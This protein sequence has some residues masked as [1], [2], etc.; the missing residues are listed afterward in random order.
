MNVTKK[1]REFIVL[2]GES[3]LAALNKLSASSSKTLFVVENSGVLLGSVTDGDFRRWITSSNTLDLEQPVDR[4]MN[5]SCVS[6]P[7]TSQ[8]SDIFRYFRP[9]CKFIPLTDPVGRVVAVAHMNNNELTLGHWT[10]SENTPVFIIAEIG[11]NHNADI[12]MARSLIDKSISAGA[13]CVKFQM[14]DMK[15]LY[16]LR[17]DDVPMQLDLSAQYTID[18]LNKFQLDDDSLFTLFDYCHEK[19]VIPLCTPW[20]SSSLKKLDSYGMVGFK[21]ASADLTNHELLRQAALTNKPLIVSTGMST[22]AE[23][24]GSVSLLRHEAASFAL[25]HCNSTYPTP[26]K[27]VR[28]S[29]LKRL[30]ELS[31]SIVGY[32]GHERGIEVPIAAVALG[33]RIIEKHITL[34]KNLPG[35]DH[36]V[37]L[38]PEEFAEMVASI[39]IVEESLGDN[40]ERLVTQGELINREALAKSLFATRTLSPGDVITRDDISIKS[41][42]QGLP[43][44]RLPE[45]LGKKAVRTISSGSFYTERDITKISERKSFYCFNRPFGIPVRYHDFRELSNVCNLDFVEFHPSYHDL[46]IDPSTIIDANQKIGFSIH[47]PELFE[48]EHILDLASPDRSYRD[49]SICYLQHVVDIGNSLCNIFSDNFQP[50]IIINAGGWSRSGFIHKEDRAMLYDLV[51]GSLEKVDFGH[52]QPAIQTMPPFPWHFGGQSHHNIFIDPLEIQEFSVKTGYK[53]CLDTSHSMMACNFASQSLD[54]FLELVLPVTCYLHIV[55]AEG[56]DGEGVQIG[57]G[58]IPFNRLIDKL[59]THGPTLPFIPEIWQG[60]KNGGEGFRNAL[61]FL[62]RLGL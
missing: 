18:M 62:E 27:D 26:F 33:A 51:H 49:K 21:I 42:G 6:C 47:C 25:L 44:N 53:I 50:A 52:L 24:T 48:D 56:T 58:D 22:E 15:C 12:E 20:D 11:N 16:N 35:N 59:L 38:L 10:I 8:Y 60:H 3:I 9:D 13:N 2:S 31:S 41:P 5:R 36:K 23:I 46:K 28:L 7:Q 40:N 17:D 55:D 43:P 57:Q 34:N 45:L 37:S 19:G 29:Y 1:I 54:D 4:I 30:K 61:A 39:R 32:S 14:R